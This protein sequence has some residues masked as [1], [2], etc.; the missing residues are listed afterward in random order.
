MRPDTE[1]TNAARLLRTKP[2]TPLGPEV[3][4]HLAD[5]LG[6][7]PMLDPSERGGDECGW[8]G[9]NHALTIARVV[10]GTGR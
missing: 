3:V 5:W 7:L 9:G 2:D 1:L 8:C 6:C 4:E 10:N